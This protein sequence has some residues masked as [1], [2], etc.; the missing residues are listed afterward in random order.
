M[1]G[2]YV[3]GSP[4]ADRQEGV[5]F[6]SDNVDRNKFSPV[7]FAFDSYEVSG[8][9]RDKVEQVASFMQSGAARSFWPVSRTNAARR[10]TTAVSVNAAP[11]RCAQR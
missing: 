6:L 11:R 9:E 2:D 1:D 3:S 10:N 5:S 7:Y 8:G 4:L